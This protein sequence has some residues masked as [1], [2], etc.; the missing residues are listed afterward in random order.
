MKTWKVL[1]VL[2]LLC[3]AVLAACTVA[4]MPADDSMAMEDEGPS[5]P[6]TLKFLALA[7]DDQLNAWKEML[8]EF[9]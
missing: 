7:D 4:P 9:Q 6:V 2:M 3:A 8:A 1:A 5:G